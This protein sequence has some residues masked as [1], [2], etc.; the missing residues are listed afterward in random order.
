MF[1]EQQ[2]GRSGWMGQDDKGGWWE[3]MSERKSGWYHGGGI[4]GTIV[5][6]SGFF[7]FFKTLVTMLHIRFSDLIH[8]RAESLYRFS[9]F[10]LFLPLP[11]PWQPILLSVS[12]SFILIF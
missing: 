10:T 9:N 12:V 8:L 11:S 5:Q 3:G 7:F 1:E 2:G 6:T 4:L